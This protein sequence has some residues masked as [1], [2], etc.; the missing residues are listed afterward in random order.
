MRMPVKRI[1]DLSIEGKALR[2]RLS[3]FGILEKNGRLAING[4]RPSTFPR[5]PAKMP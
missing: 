5:T 1:H 4:C 3:E 2:L